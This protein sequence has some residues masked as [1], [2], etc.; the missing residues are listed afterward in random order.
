M[1][2]YFIAKQTHR[3]KGSRLLLP[4]ILT[5]IFQQIDLITDLAFSNRQRHGQATAVAQG[6][7][8]CSARRHRGRQPGAIK[9]AHRMA[10]AVEK[11]DRNALFRA[12]RHHITAQ[13]HPL[14]GHQHRLQMH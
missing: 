5:H 9:A 6:G 10:A 13:A 7:Q 14:A 3:V 12:G 4:T 11:V 1:I 2:L 8:L